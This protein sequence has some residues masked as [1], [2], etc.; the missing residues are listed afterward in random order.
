M[1]AKSC[2]LAKKRCKCQTKT[3]ESVTEVVLIGFSEV[4]LASGSVGRIKKVAVSWD[5]AEASVV[6]WV[7]DNH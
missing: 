3:Q 6:V 1:N 4:T 5:F 7:N 2:E